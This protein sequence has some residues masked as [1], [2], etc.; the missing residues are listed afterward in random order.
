M[1]NTKRTIEEKGYDSIHR[2]R[3]IEGVLQA[4]QEDYGSTFADSNKA[5]MAARK[6]FSDAEYEEAAAFFNLNVNTGDPFEGWI[7]L[8]VPQVLLPKS[9]LREVGIRCLQSQVSPCAA[10]DLKNEA[11]TAGFLAG[12]SIRSLLAKQELTKRMSAVAD[13]KLSVWRHPDGQAKAAPSRN[14]A[15]QRRT[16]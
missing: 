2:E 15:E 5:F 3:E 7:E 1:G 8:E 9:V 16:G 13:P 6:S 4:L 12:V 14:C 10:S 11:G